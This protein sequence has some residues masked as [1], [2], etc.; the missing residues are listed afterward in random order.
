MTTYKSEDARYKAWLAAVGGLIPTRSFISYDNFCMIYRVEE[1]TTMDEE[2]LVP[3]KKSIVEKLSSTDPENWFI[4][5]PTVIYLSQQARSVLPEKVTL[6]VYKT[7]VWQL[8][9]A[10]PDTSM[11][12]VSATNGALKDIVTQCQKWVEENDNAS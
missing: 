12:N 3:I 7:T 6:E 2:I 8:A 9:A 11:W 4:S 5:D 1:D 10:Y